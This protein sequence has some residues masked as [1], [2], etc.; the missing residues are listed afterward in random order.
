MNQLISSKFYVGLLKVTDYVLLGMLWVVTSLPIITIGM[1]S[2]AILT[3]LHQ[4]DKTGTGSII[5]RY[6]K[7]FRHHTVVALLN[8]IFYIVGLGTIAFLFHSDGLTVPVAVGLVIAFVMATMLFL[9]LTQIIVSSKDKKI[10]YFDF[11]EMSVQSIFLNLFANLLSVLIVYL[12]YSIVSVFP[13][14]IFVFAGGIW[15]L[16]Y[17]LISRRMK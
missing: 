8:G 4:W 11:F 3:V 5:I 17:R 13:P 12:S 2:S 7:A 16:L 6:F 15:Q 9:N 1:T 14:L 10:T